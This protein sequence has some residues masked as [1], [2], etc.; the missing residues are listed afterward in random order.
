[1]QKLLHG[2]VQVECA[3]GEQTHSDVTELVLLMIRVQWV[4]VGCHAQ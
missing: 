4:L 2:S 3:A 1:M